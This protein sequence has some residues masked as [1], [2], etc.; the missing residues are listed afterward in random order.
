MNVKPNPF[1]YMSIAFV[2][3]SVTVG[4]LAFTYQPQATEYTV[5]ISTP[6]VAPTHFAIQSLSITGTTTGTAVIEL[7]DMF[8]DVSFDFEA[9]KDSYGVPGSEFTAIEITNLSVE[10][11]VSQAGDQF[12]DFTDADDHRNIN[13]LIAAYIERN[14][15]VEAV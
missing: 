1:S 11:I 7:D 14:Q 2:A 13:A 6:N 4:A 12:S 15:L 5:R 3:C 9:H 10:K 8:V